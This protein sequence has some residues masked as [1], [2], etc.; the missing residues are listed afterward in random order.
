MASRPLHFIWI[1]DCS[2]SMNQDGKIQTLN[3][4]IRQATPEL[5]K[6]AAK[7]PEAQVLLRAVRFY[8]RTAEWHI[9]QPTPA[10]D[11]H[12]QDVTADGETPMGRALALVAEELKVPPMSPRSIP[13]VLI[14]VSD[15]Q[16][17]DDFDAG[18]RA[19]MAQPWGPEPSGWPLA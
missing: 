15:G 3:M 18:L 11:F 5:Q 14:L 19:L 12:W 6:T 10:Q 2:G 16:P 9:S 8:Q 1:L 13:P 7:H 4:A 17:T